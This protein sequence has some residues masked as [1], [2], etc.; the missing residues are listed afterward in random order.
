MHG[1]YGLELFSQKEWTDILIHIL[2][3]WGDTMSDCIN[4]EEL[5]K[6]YNQ[7]EIVKSIGFTVGQGQVFAFL[8]PNGAGKSTTMNMVGT[9]LPKSKG[10]IF[11]DGINIDTHKSEIKRKIGI[12]FQEDVLDEDLTIEKNLIYRGAFYWKTDLELRKQVDKVVCKLGLEDILYKKYKECSGGQKRLAQIARA[13]IP[14]PKLLILDEPTAGLDPVISSHVWTVL[15]ELKK[16]QNMTIFYTTHYLDEASYADTI[17]ILKE[18]QILV[19]GSLKQI[20]QQWKGN[21]KAPTLDEIYF[22]L[23]KGDSPCVISDIL[24]KEI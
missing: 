23:L 15:Q 17:C 4:V 7:K 6:I 1:I 14:K 18:G 5:S 11:I 19:C 9:L 3:L 22:Q 13:I 12:V 21:R 20:Q 10:S 16:D 8:G 24:C 2:I